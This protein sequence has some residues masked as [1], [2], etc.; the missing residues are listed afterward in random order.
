MTSPNLSFRINPTSNAMTEGQTLH[1]ALTSHFETE[2]SKA[3][4]WTYSVRNGSNIY[5]QIDAPSNSPVINPPK[6]AFDY[7]SEYRVQCGWLKH[8]YPKSD[9]INIFMASKDTYQFVW[10]FDHDNSQVT[11]LMFSKIDDNFAFYCDFI[12]NRY[13]VAD[14]TKKTGKQYIAGFKVD[15][16]RGFSFIP[17][18]DFT[19]FNQIVSVNR[20]MTVFML[21]IKKLPANA[22]P[23][24]PTENEML[25]A[26]KFRIANKAFSIENKQLISSIKL[27]I[28]NQGA[29]TFQLPVGEYQCEKKLNHYHIF[30]IKKGWLGSKEINMGA[31]ASNETMALHLLAG[32]I[33]M[34][35]ANSRFDIYKNIGESHV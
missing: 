14:Q 5:L 19:T 33:E 20:L 21:M 25:E 28:T 30:Q 16:H 32:D 34:L 31:I 10:T 24:F 35:N 3:L 13:E 2:N 15:E 1:Q 22:K 17:D 29:Q 8:P 7:V 6:M 26:L 23:F 9:R 4:H 12:A 11:S 27:A 18:E